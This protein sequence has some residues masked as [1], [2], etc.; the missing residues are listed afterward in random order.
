M[1]SIFNICVRL[2]NI[3]QIKKVKHTKNIVANAIHSLFHIGSKS[4]CRWQGNLIMIKKT[5]YLILIG[6][7]FKYIGTVDTIIKII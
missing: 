3:P 6:H 4:L 1:Y 5:D 7:Y 2:H